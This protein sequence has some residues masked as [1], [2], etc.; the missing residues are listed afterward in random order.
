MSLSKFKQGSVLC[1]EGEPLSHLLFITNGSVEVLFNGQ[2]FRFEKGDTIGLCGLSMGSHSHTYTAVS[3]VTVFL[4]PYE[5]FSTLETLLRDNPD[6]ANLMVNS[7]CR[8]ISEFLEYRSALKQEADKAYESVREMY[9]QYERLCALYAV[10]SKKLSEMSEIM[11]FSKSDPVEDWVHDYYIEIKELDSAVYKA[12]FYRKPG[13]SSGFLRRGTEDILQVLQSCKGYHENLKAVSQ[14]FLNSD[15]H[16]LFALISELHFSSINI[17]GADAAVETLM[18]QL[19][20][21]LSSMTGTDVDVAYYQ[22]RL[23][24]YKANLVEKR[25][26]QEITDVP[27][28]S[29]LKQNLSDSL[30]VILEYSELPEEIRNKFAR[31]VHEYT[32]RSDRDGSDD[33]IRRLRK[34]LTES[35]YNIYKDVFIK[36]LNDSALPTII[37]MFL[38]FGYVDAT[39]A[40]HDNADF[41]YSIADSLKGDQDIGVYTLREWLT[42]IYNG[43]KEPCRNE[44]DEDYAAYLHEMKVQRKIDAAE[45]ARLLEDLEGKL[46]FEMENVFPIVNKITFG[47]ITTFCPLFGDH[48]VQRTLEASLVTPA[49]L[50]EM[51]DEIRS[52]DFSA[53]FRPTMY[54]NPEVGVPKETVNVEVLPDIILMPNVGIRG[55]MWQEI[56]GRKRTTPSRMFMPLFLLTDLKTLIIQLTGE[57][58]WEMC[59]RI[60]GTRWND[61]SDPSLTSEFCDYLQFYKSNR[62][63]ST[64]IKAQIKTELVRAKNNYK[65][66]FV[67]NYAEWLLYESN[68]SPRL[69]KNARKTMV[70]YCPFPAAIR[71]KLMLNPRYSD[72]LNRWNFK[73]QQRIQHLER[74][75]YKIGQTSAEVPQELLD[76]LEFAKS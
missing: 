12:F 51:I 14:I 52:I 70:T 24:A 63:L 54:S 25:A 61:L 22:K 28:G 44:F 2:Q 56:E 49:L 57:F 15:G 43:Q 16:D 33:D 34:E 47:R 76:E 46:R 42:A 20:G 72:P 40:G 75:T 1:S 31:Q 10:T 66:V 73:Q 11:Q 7:M 23:N 35:F 8:Q 67:S 68:S 4:Y 74:L 65:A 41:L 58:R 60:Q 21:L 37:K 62:E 17:K 5:E 27:T 64:E 50:K 55:A 18:T 71:E 36:S 39:L 29:G 19:T 48:N 38:N 59:K 13:I 32:K 53:Y 26:S 9:P 45:E 3:N 30:N 69:N 6:V